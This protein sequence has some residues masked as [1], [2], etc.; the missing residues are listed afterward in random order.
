MELIII[1]AI[2]RNGV[3]GAEGRI[4]WHITEDFKRFKLLTTGHPVIMGRKTYQSIYQSLG[5][6]LPGRI[7]VVLSR[8]ENFHPEGTYVFSSLDAALDSL[9]EQKPRP[10]GIDY[11]SA[12]IIGGKRVYEE[13]FSKV[14]RLEIT[15][16]H[17]D[18]IGDT[19]FPEIDLQQWQERERENKDGYSFA[20]YV[21]K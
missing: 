14:D 20:T 15:H 10:E 5:S 8:Q 9:Q 18:V 21:R 7:N 16:I 17:R 1:A 4:P 11:S 2:S 6:V 3:I 12:F 13:A 19:Y